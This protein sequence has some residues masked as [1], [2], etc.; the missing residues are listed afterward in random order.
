MNQPMSL[1]DADLK[2][3][4]GLNEPMDLAE[5]EEI[6]LPLS[7]LLNFYVN[8][9]DQLSTVTHDFLM[10]RAVDVPFVIGVAGSVAVGKSTTARILRELLARWPGTPHVQLVTTDGFLYPNAELERRNI[11]H[12]KGFPESYDR[13]GLLNFLAAVKS[14]E[15][16]VTAPVYSHLSYDIVPDEKVVVRQPEVLIVEGLNVLQAPVSMPS[17]GALAVSDFFDFS[18]YVDAPEPDIQRWYIERFL[19]LRETAFANP[20][21]YF[22]RYSQLTD[23]QARATAER[24][25]REINGPNLIENILPTRSRAT[26]VLTKG[27]HHLVQKVRL[28]KL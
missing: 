6:Y 5:V 26:L 21:S 7:R 12:R 20:D 24:I 18:V 28:R 15:P 10:E 1:D 25:W 14:G 9:S 23:D 4:Q 11:L 3:L 22:H 16:V 13:R 19:R 2:R 17:G 27:E 8:A